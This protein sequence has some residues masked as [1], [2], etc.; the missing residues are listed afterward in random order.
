MKMLSRLLLCLL[1]LTAG[2][3]NAQETFVPLISENCVAFIHV[4]FS[5]VELDTVKAFVQKTG[6]D[7]LT[8][9]SFDPRSHQATARE[10]AFELEKLDMLV[11]PTFE[12]ITQEIGIREYAMILDMEILMTG[13]GGGIMAVSWKDKTDAQLETLKALLDS[14]GDTTLSRHLF[15]VDNFLILPMA[16]EVV[17]VKTFVEGWLAKETPQNSPILEALQ[18]V[19]DRE[20]KFAAA[21]PTQAR[22]LIQ[23]A[24]LPPDVPLEVRNVLLFAAQ[25]IDWASAGISL[26]EILGVEPPKNADVLMTVKMS[27]PSNARMMYGMLENLIEFGMNAARFGFDQQMRDEDFQIPPLVWQF[28]KG[29]LRTLLPD[30]EED[31]LIFRIKAQF[32]G[33]DAMA[34][35]VPTVGVGIALLLPAVQAARE[36]AR[37]MQCANNIKLI[38]L[39]LHNYHDTRNTLPPLYTVDANGKPLHS[40]RVLILPFIEQA[41][42]YN[43]IRLDEPW[44]SPH[45]SQFHGAVPSYFLCPSNH[46]G[47]C[48]YSVI[49]GEG[50]VPATGA[51]IR[52]GKG[53]VHITDG[54]SNTIA[55]VEV[56]ESFNWM[57]PTADITFEEF[58]QG[59]NV[60]GGRMGSWHPGGMNV[61]M[62]DGS[63]R[64]M[65]QSIHI[66]VL[67]ALG[68]IAG[69]ESRVAW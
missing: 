52:T 5:K 59:I 3:A 18:S 19:A 16:D 51:N 68:T 23:T 9:L 50:F 64:F 4:D 28:A 48:C 49:A 53:F 67:R 27:S 32:P 25:R 14:T 34:L 8:T 54:M 42:L 69:G 40:W 7:F 24:P 2:K 12:T 20:I 26:Q 61:G 57:D 55:I 17:P 22:Q 44:D 29:F 47:G 36:A 58:V 30:V 45:N 38:T 41:A 33:S 66:D 43:A 60:P 15:T 10:L 31:K 62:F 35:A 6:E 1:L 46:N 56:R 21:I 39:A 11:R 37:R 65:A 63:V 13:R